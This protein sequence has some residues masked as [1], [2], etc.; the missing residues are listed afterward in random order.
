MTSKE[1]ARRRKALGTQEQVAAALGF[2]SGVH[3]SRIETG[4]RGCRRWHALA[5]R[6]LEDHPSLMDPDEKP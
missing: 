6:A 4:A 2:G 5:I 3:L 1:F